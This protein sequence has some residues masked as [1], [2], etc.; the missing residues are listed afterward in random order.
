[1]GNENLVGD[2]NMNNISEEDKIKKTSSEDIYGDY[3]EEVREI[4]KNSNPLKN[5]NVDAI[6]KAVREAAKE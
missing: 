2:K 1:M 5:R 6:E 4:L 3:P